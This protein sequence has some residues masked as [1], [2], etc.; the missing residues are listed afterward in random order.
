MQG[1]QPLADGDSADPTL[2]KRDKNSDPLASYKQGGLEVKRQLL[3]AEGGCYV[4]DRAATLLGISESALTALS[5]Q[6]KIIGLPLADGSFVYPQWQFVKTLFSRYRL[7]N[8]LDRVLAVISD[9][10]PWIQT[11]FM[12]DRL[13]STEMTTPLDGLRQGKIDVVITIAKSLGEQGVV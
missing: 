3:A 4:S 2:R 10:D 13:I 7:L 6:S 12:L 1:S 8:G 11:A 9:S 5:Q